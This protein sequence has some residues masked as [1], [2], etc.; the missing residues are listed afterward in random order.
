MELYAEVSPKREF[1]P[2]GALLP[3]GLFDNAPLE[4]WLAGNMAKLGVPNYFADFYR[5]TGRKLYITA[6]NLDTAERVLFGP[7]NDHGLT[8]S[9]AVQALER[10][11]RLLQARAHQRGRLRRRRG[12]PHREHRRRGGAG[13][14]PDHLLQPVPPVLERPARAGP[15]R[16]PLP[17]R[18]RAWP[19][20]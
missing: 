7:E 2:I 3:S 4:R 16:Q 9:E 15:G 19:P 6:T 13:G 20:C 14:R 1:P 17:G 12:A 18:S 8:I 5:E 11:A 10:A